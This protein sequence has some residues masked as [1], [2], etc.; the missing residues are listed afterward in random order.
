MNIGIATNTPTNRSDLAVSIFLALFFPSGVSFAGTLGDGEL[1]PVGVLPGMLVAT[2]A[3]RCFDCCIRH[4]FETNSS[5]PRAR[6]TD[7]DLIDFKT[8]SLVEVKS[9]GLHQVLEGQVISRHG[10]LGR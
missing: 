7:G 1:P 2:L 10:Y 9:T 8:S 6:S 4:L 5:G 3:G